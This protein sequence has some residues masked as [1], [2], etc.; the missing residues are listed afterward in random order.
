MAACQFYL[1]LEKLRNV[2]RMGN[3]SHVVFGQKFLGEK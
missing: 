1:Q 2:G 3:D